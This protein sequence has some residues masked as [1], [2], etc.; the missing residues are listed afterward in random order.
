MWIA[1]QN[2]HNA[3]ATGLLADGRRRLA[4]IQS[5]DFANE[6]MFP[7]LGLYDCHA[8]HRSMK[9]VQ[10]RRLPRHANAGPGVPFVSDGTFVMALA[11]TQSVLPSTAEELAESLSLLHAAGSQSV[12]KIQ[13]AAAS[14]DAVLV[15]VQKSLSEQ[16]LNKQQNAIL[17]QILRQGA[18]GEFLDYASAE[19]AFMA[20][21]MLSFELKDITLQDEID[22]L[23][24]SLDD[25]ERYWPSQFARLLRRLGDAE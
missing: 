16:A 8:C 20:V 25:D 19:Q 6:G 3:W 21:Q 15:S 17:D 14:L 13:S 12:E 9:S 7:E 5:D 24:K 1:K 18:A 10:W 2:R 23:A 11:L 4:L 22:T